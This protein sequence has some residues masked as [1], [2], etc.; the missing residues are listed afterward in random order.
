[1]EVAGLRATLANVQIKQRDEA[2][3][4]RRITRHLVDQFVADLRRSTDAP[5]VLFF[6]TV[7]DASA[8]VCDW[9]MDTLLVQLSPLLHVRVVV[10][11]RSMPEAS[12]S[13][14][15]LCCSYQLTPVE[16]DEAYITYCQQVGAVLVEQSIRDF[17]RVFEYK[18][19]LFV[20]YVLPKF[21]ARKAAHG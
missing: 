1:V 16:E 11:G 15:A 2:G 5:V 6:D 10:A 20:D 12:G 7:N 9:L 18:P 3:E 4:E 21:V 14:A 19:G 17:A 13:Y 8:T